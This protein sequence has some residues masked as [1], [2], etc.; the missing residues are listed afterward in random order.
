M[1]LDT[2]F[3]LP[4]HPLL[5]H[6]VVVLLPLACLGA[7]AIA[8]RFSWR[9]RFGTLVLAVAVVATLA[10]PLVTDSGE[11]LAARVGNPADHAEQ[12]DAVK[13]YVIP[14][15]LLLIA[16]LWWSRPS[17]AARSFPTQKWFL[18]LRLA[19]VFMSLSTIVGIAITG[20]SGAQATWKKLIANTSPA[21]G[22]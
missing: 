12:G 4:V 1:N 3:G 18:V 2:I 11:S 17:Q 16:M 9:E 15:I 14:W 13:F 10:V 21:A 19:V 22:G 20:H 5:V 6:A 8:L 7:T